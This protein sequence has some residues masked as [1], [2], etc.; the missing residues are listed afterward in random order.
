MAVSVLVNGVVR[1]DL[2]PGHATLELDVVDVDADVGNVHI[3][4]L[5]PGRSHS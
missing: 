1:N 2:A 3:N 4:I 5:T